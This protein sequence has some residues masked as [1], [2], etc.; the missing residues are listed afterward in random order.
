MDSGLQ[1][2]YDRLMFEHVDRI[3]LAICKIEVDIKCGYGAANAAGT[4]DV[5]EQDAAEPTGKGTRFAEGGEL[6]IGGDEGFLRGIL[7]Q[8]EVTQA[9][10]TVTD[11]HIL[12]R[13]DNRLVGS[14]ITR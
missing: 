5:L 4:V 1:G 6:K 13:T 2:V 7:G 11:R 3:M 8:L 14:G 12:K 9:G 10:I